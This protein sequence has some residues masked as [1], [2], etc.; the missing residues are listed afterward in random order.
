MKNKKIIVLDPG[1]GGQDPGAVANG[2]V[3]KFIVWELAQR[4]KEKLAGRNAEIIIVQPSLS[5]PKSTARD[6]LY[7]PP[8]EANRL[9][10]DFYLSLHV[11]AGGGEGFESFVHPAAKNKPADALRNRLHSQI[12]QYLAR[13]KVKDRGCKYADFAVLRLTHMPA[14]LLECLFMDHTGDAQLLKN[15]DF[16]DGLANEIAY[17]LM[18]TLS[19]E[20]EA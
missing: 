7:K 3:E 14:V 5:N 15:H 17:G 13:H 16:L 8:Q 20:G 9:K 6:E 11:N 18:V 1:H 2:L 10:A 4:V 19:L 12:M